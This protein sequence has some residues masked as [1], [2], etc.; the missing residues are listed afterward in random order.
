MLCPIK[1]HSN[2]DPNTTLLPSF[3]GESLPVGFCAVFSLTS[4]GAELS[5]T[6]IGGS[7]REMAGCLCEDECSANESCCVRILRGASQ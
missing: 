3:Q 4:V 7:R 1:G 5:T 6:G 2:P